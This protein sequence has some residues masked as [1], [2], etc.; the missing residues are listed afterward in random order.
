M[1]E[2]REEALLWGERALGTLT[3][4]CYFIPIHFNTCK[5]P[6]E[7]FLEQT[8]TQS[9]STPTP[10]ARSDIFTTAFNGV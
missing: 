5:K 1:R 7:E 4:T 3:L 8:G 2:P 6:K 9:T 10:G